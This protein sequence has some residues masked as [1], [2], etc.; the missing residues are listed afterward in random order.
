MY[1]WS[2]VKSGGE[3]GQVEHLGCKCHKDPSS[4]V[5]M[6]FIYCSLK[7]KFPWKRTSMASIIALVK[8]VIGLVISLTHMVPKFILDSMA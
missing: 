1:W 6:G 7:F 3:S 4:Q 5:P 2:K 8:G